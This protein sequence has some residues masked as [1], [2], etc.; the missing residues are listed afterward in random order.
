M[1]QAAPS[2]LKSAIKSCF[3]HIRDVGVVVIKG[4]S[5]ELGT[6]EELYE[7]IKRENKEKKSFWAYRNPDRF[8]GTMKT[9]ATNV[10]L[11]VR[12]CKHAGELIKTGLIIG[13]VKR[14]VE[15]YDAGYGKRQQQQQRPQ[16]P[17]S[18]PAAMRGNQ[19]QP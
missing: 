3:P 10:K 13:G 11:E 6:G 1:V 9:G 18:A 4:V 15:F 7:T 5:R 2:T 12:S 17:P 14:A 19:Y 16:Q 8:A